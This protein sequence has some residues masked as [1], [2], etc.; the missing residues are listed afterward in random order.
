[1]DAD[2]SKT[3][4]GRGMTE[5][6]DLQSEKLGKDARFAVAGIYA[7][8]AL[9]AFALNSLM[10][11]TFIKDR[12]LLVPSNLPI[13]SISVADWLMA[14]VANPI[15]VAANLS[16]AWSLS[17]GPCT[18]YAFATTTLAFAVMLHHTAIAVEKYR[19]LTRPY[20][21]E[22]PRKAMLTVIASLWLF[23]LFW[24]IVPL[25]GWSAY[26]PEAGGT[27]CSIKWQSPDA[28]DAAYIYAIF[29]LFYFAPLTI[30]TLAYGLVYRNVKQMHQKA[31]STWGANFG[32]TLD[33][34]EAK[35]KAAKL[36]F[37]MVTSFMLGWT[38][39]AVVSL[40]ATRSGAREFPVV[41]GVIPALFAKTTTSYNPVIYFLMYDRFRESLK[42][43]IAHGVRSARPTSHVWMRDVKNLLT[44][45]DRHDVS[46][47]TYGN[48]VTSI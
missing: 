25:F 24:S 38:P 10:I 31:I 33:A 13:L 21:Q 23:A 45:D 20:A 27:A 39:Y 11:F 16:E 29:T 22:V 6:S 7:S 36:S 41:V 34:Q 44:Y 8:L 32:P 19:F 3:F 42:R 48:Q 26:V 40:M 14:V 28:A 15:G 46:P 47:V 9:A 18:F 37:L 12:S 1:M 2:W 5:E 43:S 4:T 35:V 17:G 30:I